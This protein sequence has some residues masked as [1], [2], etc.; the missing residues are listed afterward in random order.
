MSLTNLAAVRINQEKR[1]KLGWGRGGCCKASPASLGDYF[2]F[3]AIWVS[4]TCYW[5][6]QIPREG[7]KVIDKSR[8]T[9]LK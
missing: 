2:W 6:K 9:M 5:D 3:Q 8:K 7:I 1:V 4:K